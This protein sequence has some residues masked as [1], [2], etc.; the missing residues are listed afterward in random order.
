[1]SAAASQPV[2]QCPAPVSCLAFFGELNWIDGRLLLP[3]IEPYRRQFFTRALDTY[4][5]DGVPQYNFVLAGR[6]KKNHK[7]TD[8]VLTALYCLL[9]RESSAGN[10]CFI[11]ANDEDQAGDDLSLAKKLVLANSVLQA[12]LIVLEKEIRRRDGR[13]SLKILPARDVAGLHGKTAIFIGYDEIHGYKN[14]DL[15]EALAPDPTRPDVLIWITSYDTIHARPGI[16]LYDFK[17]VGIEGSD[18]RM[19]FSW[20]SGD[21][22]TDPDFAELEPELRA[23][24]SIGSWPEGRAYLDQ[25]RKR[26]PTH[27]YRRL[28]LNLPG[29]PEGAFLDQG[30]VLAA[31]MSGLKSIPPIDG[32]KYRAFVD[33]SGGSSDDAVLAIAHSDGSKAV[34][35]LIIKQPGS[36][37]FNP[38]A[39]V[40]KFAGAIIEYGL[41]E[42]TGDNYAGETFKADFSSFGIEYRS[43]DLNKTE[44]YEAFEPAIN[45][46]EIELLD[47]PILQEQLL[48]LVVRGSRVD[49]QPGG[50]DDWANA[51][52]GA[53][54]LVKNPRRTFTAIT[55]PMTVFRKTSENE[56]SPFAAGLQVPEDRIRRHRILGSSQS[57][58]ISV[59]GASRE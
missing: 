19:V 39:A 2:V 58:L 29:A 23:N 47:V 52:A 10:D 30:A 1:M 53:L 33:M 59:G 31:V 22:C 56:R 25:Q 41:W 49:H 13:G 38:R 12:E 34:L 3:K 43:S 26:L 21:L 51:A 17:L 24:P 50:H 32:R 40:Q 46:G 57:G 18:P 6:G 14:Y 35:D 28:H 54:Q 16:P 5:D 45:A 55:V 20:Y 44:I 36:V 27:K 4:R 37:P 48:T 8:L 42:V 9:I 7:S 15:F 11:L